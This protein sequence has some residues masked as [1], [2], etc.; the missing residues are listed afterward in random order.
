MLAGRIRSPMGRSGGG[1]FRLASPQPYERLF[2]HGD[3]RCYGP[4]VRG[5][6]DPFGDDRI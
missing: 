6:L 2:P 5:R 3:D 4:A 1:W